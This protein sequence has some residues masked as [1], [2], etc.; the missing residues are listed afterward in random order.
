MTTKTV[1]EWK[2]EWLDEWEDILDCD[3]YDKFADAYK[4]SKENRDGVS[5]TLVLV[6][7]V[8]CDAHGVIDRQHAY[9]ENGKFPHTFDGG[10]PVPIRF[11]GEACEGLSLLITQQMEN[12][13]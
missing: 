6:R 3:H 11:I 4:A 13:G 1:Y 7:D 12:I 9:M 2:V 10:A 5:G 8:V